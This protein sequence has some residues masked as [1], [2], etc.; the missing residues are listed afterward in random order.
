MSTLEEML[1]RYRELES[2]AI[3]APD[4]TTRN[5]AMDE[6]MNLFVLISKDQQRQFEKQNARIQADEVRTAEIDK[7]LAAITEADNGLAQIPVGDERR[8]PAMDRLL[9]LRMQLDRL[10]TFKE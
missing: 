1:T 9:S 8:G 2:I 5:R 7:V 10:M 3:N 4:A 6:R